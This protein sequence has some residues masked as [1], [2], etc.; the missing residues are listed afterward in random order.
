MEALRGEKEPATPETP[1][2]VTKL[3]SVLNHVG[4][5]GK[6]IFDPDCSYDEWLDVLMALASTGW[7]CAPQIADLWS[8]QAK[9]PDHYPG[10]D[11]VHAKMASFTRGRDGIT[12]RSLYRAAL[13][14]DWSEPLPTVPQD[15]QQEGSTEAP[16]AW[17][18]RLQ[19][20]NYRRAHTERQ[21]CAAVSRKRAAAGQQL[22]TPVIIDRPSG[23]LLGPHI[24]TGDDRLF[25]ISGKRLG[26]PRAASVY[27]ALEGAG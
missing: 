13:D 21:Q 1:Y 25:L 6:R 5:D 12:E 19:K 17:R 26:R 11:A 20:T 4:P 9:K 16:D 15:S 8:K 24:A 2:E 27:R 22:R 23:A 7:A 3:I 10:A 14:T 18:T